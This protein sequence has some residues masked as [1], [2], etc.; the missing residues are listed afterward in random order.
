MTAARA[1]LRYT[2]GAVFAFLY[3]PIIVLVVYSFNGQGVGGFPPRD[4]TLNWYRLLFQDDAIWSSVLNSVIVALASVTIALALG[5]PAGL[6]LDRA[7]FPGKGI[8]RRLVL[9]PL[10]LPG[11]ITGL[12]L[13]M[14][15]REAN[16]KLSL[17]TRN[18]RPRHCA[19]FGG[20]HR[21]IRRTAEA[22]PRAR[23]KLHSISEPITCRPSGALPCPISSFRSSAPRC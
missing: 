10:V 6:A 17:I 8:F 23:K 1:G 13:L 21:S 12:S 18:S 22:R 5:I 7:N 9:L 16:L 2:P 20:N 11:I 4:L 15:F 3:L 19:D 14:L